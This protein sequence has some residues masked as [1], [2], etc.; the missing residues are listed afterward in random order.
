MTDEDG[1]LHDGP[2]L[3]LC[4]SVV[5]EGAIDLQ[6]GDWKV[7]EIAQGGIT[8]P[9]VVDSNANTAMME[10]PQVLEDGLVSFDQD[11]LGQFDADIP[12]T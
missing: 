5:D 1:T 9:E 7:L 8:C 4:G 6:G 11:I 12:R 2:I 10:A 3:R